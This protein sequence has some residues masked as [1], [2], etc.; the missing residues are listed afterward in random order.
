M[1][2]KSA[3]VTFLIVFLSEL[4]DKT[5]LATMAVAAQSRSPFM[6]FV[7]A[8]GALVFSAM[9]GVL[10]GDAIA[11]WIPISVLKTGAGLT[12]V[13]FGILLIAGRS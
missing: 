9:L 1:E 3:M 11:R 13:L 7:G 12:F 10:F 6:V 5:Q 8:A 2:W 4:G